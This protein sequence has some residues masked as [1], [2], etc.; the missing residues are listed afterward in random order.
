MHHVERIDK[1]LEQNPDRLVS[2]D[3]AHGQ[4]PDR[5]KRKIPELVHRGVRAQDSQRKLVGHHEAQAPCDPE[6]APAGRITQ[7][8][9]R[10]TAQDQG[11]SAAPY[12]ESRGKREPRR[13]HCQERHAPGGPCAD[14]P[15]DRIQGRQRDRDGNRHVERVLLELARITDLVVRKRE[16][17]ESNERRA[18]GQ[19]LERQRQ[20]QD[21]SRDP[22]K[23]RYQP[24]DRFEG[25]KQRNERTLHDNEAERGQLILGELLRKL[26]DRHTGDVPP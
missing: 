26:E 19:H 9:R 8:P 25:A 4:R 10:E 15:V 21:Q 1:N 3:H 22:G 23:Q 2:P 6:R 20:K 7:A 11:Q 16:E 24:T 12:D 14:G 18:P 13:S 5:Q 17:Q